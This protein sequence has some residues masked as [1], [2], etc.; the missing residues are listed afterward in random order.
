MVTV[1]TSLLHSPVPSSSSL[2]LWVFGPEITKQLEEKKKQE[3]Y[4]SLKNLPIHY[5]DSPGSK[6]LEVA[7]QVENGSVESLQRA[8][9]A[10]SRTIATNAALEPEKTRSWWP[11]TAFQEKPVNKPPLSEAQ[12]EAQDEVANGARKPPKTT[13]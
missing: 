6:A 11:G 13:P 9:A 3:K 5:A 1:G 7:K 10:A 4:G 12:E 2:G 8:E